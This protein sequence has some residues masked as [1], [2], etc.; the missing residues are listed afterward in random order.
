MNTR[1]FVVATVFVLCLSPLSAAIGGDVDV[2]SLP[3]VKTQKGVNYLS[4]GVGQDE[5]QAVESAAKDYSLMLTFAIQKTGDYLA[6]VNVK[7]EDKSGKLVLDAVADGPMLLVQL[8]PG[9]YKISAVSNDR[10]V[11]KTVHISGNRTT[12]ETLYWPDDAAE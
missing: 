3:E 7:I 5:T 8:P 9:Q 1:K 11:I 12:R 10:Q 2:N 6:N 4:G